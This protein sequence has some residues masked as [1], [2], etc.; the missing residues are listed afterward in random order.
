MDRD[1]AA[2]MQPG[3]RGVAELLTLAGLRERRGGGAA[4]I[5]DG[6][7]PVAPL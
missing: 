3:G 2:S 1:G 5:R 7:P 4:V 6:C